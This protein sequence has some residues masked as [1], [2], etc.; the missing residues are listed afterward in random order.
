MVIMKNVKTHVCM[1]AHA[2]THDF[3]IGN[4]PLWPIHI[5]WKF[6]PDSSNYMVAAQLIVILDISYSKILEIPIL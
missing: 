6:Q 2:Y 1:H 3:K 4:I 5:S